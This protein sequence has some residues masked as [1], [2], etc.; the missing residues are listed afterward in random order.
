MVSA[1]SNNFSDPFPAT[2]AFSTLTGYEVNIW[3]D[4]TCSAASVNEIEKKQF[5][6]YPNP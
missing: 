5:S 4:I 3:M 1:M 6:V 2:G